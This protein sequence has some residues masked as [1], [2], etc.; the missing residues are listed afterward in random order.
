MQSEKITRVSGTGV[1]LTRLGKGV[2]PIIR[3]YVRQTKTLYETVVALTI[4]FES[5][6]RV[7]P[8]NRIRCEQLGEGLWHVTVHFGFVEIPDLPVAI[9]LAKR[10]GLPAWHQPIY[11]VERYDAISRANRPWPTRWRIALFSLMS[12]NSAHAVDRFKI[13]S[14]ALVEIGRRV[15][16]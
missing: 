8:V 13:P 5:V 14:S 3:N 12:R 16:L 4:S 9:A 1:F 6:P 10:E 11:Y 7:K 2:P 15:E